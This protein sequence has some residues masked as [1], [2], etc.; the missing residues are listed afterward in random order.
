MKTSL[1]PYFG[2]LNTKQIYEGISAAQSNSVRL[3]D[4]ANLLFE[5][6]R[7]PSATALAVLAIEERGKII[8]LKR[9]AI[10]QEDKELRKTWKEYRH[11]RAKNAGWII[12]E[13]VRNGT[14]K[15]HEF[16]SAVDKSAVHTFLLDNLK[17][18]S[19][20]TDCLGKRHWSIPKDVITEE[21]AKEI[22]SLAKCM[23][24]EREVTLREIELWVEHVGTHFAQATMLQAVA[25]FQTAMKREGLSDFDGNELLEFS[26]GL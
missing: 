16:R 24:C 18:I 20:Y 3:I 21:V 10:L 26:K 6:N 2:R 8:I 25:N 5:N 23:W 12:P 15:L 17:Q 22:L 9:L 4:D 11:H 13:L 19:L 7:Y 1:N 14:Q